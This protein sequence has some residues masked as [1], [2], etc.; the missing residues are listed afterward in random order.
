MKNLIALIITTPGIL[1]H[2]NANTISLMKKEKLKAASNISTSVHARVE[3]IEI[4]IF[5]SIKKLEAAKRSKNLRL[6]EHYQLKLMRLF[7]KIESRGL[8][9]NIYEKLFLK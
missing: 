9:H 5:K 6:I 2:A 7:K 8:A 1:Y 3:K 4:K